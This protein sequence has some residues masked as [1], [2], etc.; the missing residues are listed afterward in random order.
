MGIYRHET[1]NT[2]NPKAQLESSKSIHEVGPC[3]KINYRSYSWCACSSEV[4]FTLLS[5]APFACSVL[6]YW[7]CFIFILASA[8]NGGGNITLATEAS[9][10]IIRKSTQYLHID[11]K[12]SAVVRFNCDL[13]GR[14]ELVTWQTKRCQS[15]VWLMPYDLKFLAVACAFFFFTHLVC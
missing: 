15:I 9:E 8:S 3:Q 7:L 5:D 12:C 6:F 1:P 4:L 10:C 2:N 13:E 11:L 14:S